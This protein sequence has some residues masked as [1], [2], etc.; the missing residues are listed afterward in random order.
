MAYEHSAAKSIHSAET[1][2]PRDRAS[3]VHATAPT[4]ATSTHT[5]TDRGLNL[6][7][8]PG[9]R[10]SGELSFVNADDTRAS[11][12]LLRTPVRRLRG[13][14]LMIT[15]LGTPALLGAS[16]SRVSDGFCG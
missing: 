6:R 7:R 12:K 5:A 14:A 2:S 11:R 10:G 4:R 3:T 9:P 1:D 16:R 8:L 13:G 15:S